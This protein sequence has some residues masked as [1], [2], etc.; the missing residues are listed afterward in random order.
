KICFIDLCDWDYNISTAWK[1]PLGGSQSALCYLA[2]ELALRG[3]QVVHISSTLE[4]GRFKNVECINRKEGLTQSFFLKREFDVV[5]DVNGPAA[6]AVMLKK[7]LPADVPL[8]LWTGHAADQPALDGL[9]HSRVNTLWDGIVCVS[10][11]HKQKVIDQF[12][13]EAPKVHVLRNAIAPVF[14]NLFANET[15]LVESKSVEPVLTYTS[16]PF[17]GLNVL[18]ALMPAL[19]HHFPQLLLKVYSSM[20]VY[21]VEEEADK[22]KVLYDKC[23][24]TPGIDYI[25]AIPQPRLASAM[26]HIDIFSYPNTF[27][28]TSCI[29]VMEAMAA[30]LFVVTTDLG[31]LRETAMGYGALVPSE[32]AEKAEEI[33][34]VRY[35]KALSGVLLERQS[36]QNAFTAALFKQVLDVNNTC[37]WR[38]RAKEWELF[39][40]QLKKR[41]A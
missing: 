18:A 29:A 26:K 37:T 7:R 32:G 4:P 10:Q 31:A 39:I 6:A 40:L 28:E 41:L 24:S 35:L 21:Q 27:A 5:I 15:E 19:R 8:V 11:W 36:K 22:Y 1:R 17:R 23:R 9:K 38:V 25:G 34:A 12:K 33:F 14:E 20:K 3:H 2:T 30:G 13:I 16:T